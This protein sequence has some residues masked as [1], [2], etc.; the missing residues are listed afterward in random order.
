[1][2]GIVNVSDCSIFGDLSFDTDVDANN[3]DSTKPEINSSNKFP[4]ILGE[5]EFNV[6]DSERASACEVLEQR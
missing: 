2:L 3:N 1:M 4:D 5:F 6:D